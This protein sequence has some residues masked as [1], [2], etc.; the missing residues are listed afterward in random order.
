[1][2]PAQ[3]IGETETIT[4]VDLIKLEEI[5]LI[6]DDFAKAVGVASII[7]EP[8]GTPITKPVN[9]SR[10]CNDIIRKTEFGSNNCRKSDAVIGQYSIE[11][12]TIKPCLSCGM[13]DAGTSIIV[14][15]TVSEDVKLV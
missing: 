12:P 4:L 15:G 7:T 5:Q 8:D 9:F 11:G 2:Y 1:M 6:Q 13:M 10:L 3:N 14:D